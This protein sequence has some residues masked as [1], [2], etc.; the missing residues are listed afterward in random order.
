MSCCPYRSGLDL[1]WSPEEHQLGY[2]QSHIPVLM[3]SF[4]CNLPQEMLTEGPKLTVRTT[5]CWQNSCSYLRGIV[6][7]IS[8]KFCFAFT[9]AGNWVADRC[10][11]INHSQLTLAVIATCSEL[12]PAD[13]AQDGSG[14]V[15]IF[16]HF[17]C[18]RLCRSIRCRHLKRG[19]LG[20]IKL[21]VSSRL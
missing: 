10:A 18:T 11:G 17:S 8:R 21:F 12:N 14:E 20:A 13:D 6:W 1:Q 2:I 7:K 5:F 16:T 9:V 3:T 15:S 4:M 19:G